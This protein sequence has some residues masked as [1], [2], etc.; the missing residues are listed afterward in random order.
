MEE[1]EHFVRVAGV[2]FS[3]SLSLGINGGG[4]G[5]WV[6]RIEAQ[7]QVA[8]GGEAGLFVGRGEGG[9][10][11]DEGVEGVGAGPLGGAGGVGGALGDDGAEEGGVD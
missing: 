2:S 7:L 1:E 6:Q 9:G 11:G 3:L 10:G 8:E 4:G 5:M